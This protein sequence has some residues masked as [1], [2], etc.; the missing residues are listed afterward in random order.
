[1]TVMKLKSPKKILPQLGVNL[2]LAFFNCKQNVRIEEKTCG[3][4][5]KTCGLERKT[6]GLEKKTR[7]LN[8]NARIQKTLLRRLKSKTTKFCVDS[9]KMRRFKTNKR[10]TPDKLPTL[11]VMNV[12]FL[13]CKMI[14][15]IRKVMTYKVF[16]ESINSD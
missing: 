1:M 6:R 10:I 14:I 11:A 13:I 5:R 8:K 7:G 4:K 9:L 2:Y 15:V 16:H 3:L 12:R